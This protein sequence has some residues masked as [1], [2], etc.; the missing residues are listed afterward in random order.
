MTS[1]GA[2]ASASAMIPVL[3][4]DKDPFSLAADV[5]N[6]LNRYPYC[7]RIP[8][9]G[10]QGARGK[11]I[12]RLVANTAPL[13]P[14]NPFGKLTFTEIR[15][16]PI[17]FAKD[18]DG[19]RYSRTNVELAPHTDCSY[20]SDPFELVA[21]QMIRPDETG[22]E[23]LIVVGSDAL[24][25]LSPDQVRHL[26]EPVFSFGERTLPVTWGDG[27]IRYYRTQIEEHAQAGAVLPPAH[28]EAIDALDAVL[29]RPELQLRYK[30]EAG[31]ILF[32]NNVRVLHGRTGFAGTSGRLMY[33]IRV[34]AG[35]LYSS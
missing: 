21:F 19:T 25:A 13:H 5:A 8:R 7:A 34:N 24:A 3:N 6:A 2:G 32:I 22:G 28:R 10:D 15:I 29:V 27:L 4:E 1:L 9:F 23:S 26:S 33:R 12:A 30:L 11:S 31:E 35:C 17:A 20:M 14:R 18:G 16:D